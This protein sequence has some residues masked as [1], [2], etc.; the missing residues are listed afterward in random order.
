MPDIIGG[1]KGLSPCLNQ[2][3]ERAVITACGLKWHPTLVPADG[4]ACAVLRMRHQMQSRF[5]PTK[6]C[7]PAHW[8]CVCAKKG[9]P[10]LGGSFSLHAIA[11]YNNYC[12]ASAAG[13]Y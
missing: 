6:H 1:T 9:T 2:S 4:V 7:Y 10:L 13:W 8:P 11:N 3:A 12:Y 5:F